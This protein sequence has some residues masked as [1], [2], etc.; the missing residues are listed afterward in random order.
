MAVMVPTNSGGQPSRETWT[1]KS[2]VLSSYPERDPQVSRVKDCRT[3]GHAS[4]VL[5][6]TRLNK[7]LSKNDSIKIST[8]QHF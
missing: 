2:T 5:C 8:F 1:T 7:V 6:K 4:Q 3:S